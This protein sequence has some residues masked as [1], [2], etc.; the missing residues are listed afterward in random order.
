MT[1]QPSDGLYDTGG[2]EL[3]AVDIVN[4]V[5]CVGYSKFLNPVYRLDTVV[6]FFIL[7]FTM[8]YSYG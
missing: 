1:V 5:V 3:E 7:L 2:D 8:D 4:I 6:F